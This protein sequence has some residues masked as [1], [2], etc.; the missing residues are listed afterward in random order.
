[1]LGIALYLDHSPFDIPQE[2]SALMIPLAGALAVA[3]PLL[4]LDEPTVGLD[5]AQVACL[6]ELLNER[7]RAG[8]TIFISHDQAF[9]AAVATHCLD[10]RELQPHQGQSFIPD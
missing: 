3:P 9:I 5:D 4:L 8:A 1:M 6:I 10:I 7:R 2:A